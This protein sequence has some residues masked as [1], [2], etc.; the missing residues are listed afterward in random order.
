MLG[1]DVEIWERFVLMFPNE[2]DSV[3]YDVRVGEGIAPLAHLPDNIK[4]DARALTQKRIDVVGWNGES[5]TIIEVKSRAGLGVLG[6]ILGYQI[7]F[8]KDFPNIQKPGLLIIAGRIA[9]DDA[10]VLSESMIK[11][12]VV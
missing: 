7:L 11:I 5:P 2:Y 9:P 8:N 4:R 10:Y 1:A 3:D 6:Q 12:I